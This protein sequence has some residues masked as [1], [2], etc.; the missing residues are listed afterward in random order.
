VYLT[1]K[2]RGGL[3]EYKLHYFPVIRLLWLYVQIV[4]PHP[5]ETREL[6]VAV[7]S[8]L[9]ASERY[10]Q[11]EPYQITFYIEGIVIVN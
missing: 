4:L 11:Y 5:E 6:S 7:E 10:E 1:T 9:F 8:R 3:A 2:N